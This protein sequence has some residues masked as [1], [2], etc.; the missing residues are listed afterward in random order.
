MWHAGY[1]LD[2]FDSNVE[3]S[4][5]ANGSV[6]A[7][8]NALDDNVCPTEAILLFSSLSGSFSGHLGCVSSP[9]FAAAEATGSSAGL[10]KHVTAQVTESD[11]SVIESSLN[12]HLTGSNGSL[13]F[14]LLGCRLFRFSHD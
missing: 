14:L 4:Q 13:S 5:S 11:D 10:G 8:A 6:T 3:A 7:K 2:A 9:F 12:V 1:I